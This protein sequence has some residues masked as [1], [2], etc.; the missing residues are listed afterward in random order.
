[1]C[2]N[3]SMHNFANWMNWLNVSSLRTL[4][5]SSAWLPRQDRDRS[6]LHQSELLTSASNES[7]YRKLQ[8]KEGEPVSLDYR[9]SWRYLCSLFLDMLVFCII[10]DRLN[11]RL[12]LPF[13][14]VSWIFRLHNNKYIS[15]LLYQEQQKTTTN[16]LFHSWIILIVPQL[17][18]QTIQIPRWFLVLFVSA[19]VCLFA[20][21]YWRKCALLS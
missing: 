4:P 1:M 6:W 17:N 16:C 12:H 8:V 3:I 20:S 9:L 10:R 19:F 21:Q 15:S 13:T 5:A 2:I 11:N 7:N 14:A 18:Y